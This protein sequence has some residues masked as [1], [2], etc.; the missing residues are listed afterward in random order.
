M[1]GAKANYVLPPLP[2]LETKTDDLLLEYL[3]SDGT[4][5]KGADYEV[6]LSD[7]SIRKGKLDASGKAI[8]SG[9]PAGR[10]KIQYGE[11]QSKDEFPVLEIDDWFI[12]SG[13]STK[14]GKEE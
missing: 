4:P 12:Q 9:V 8:V 6:L 7:G 14:T 13:S 11:D 1:G 5:V 10:A 3:H 2:A